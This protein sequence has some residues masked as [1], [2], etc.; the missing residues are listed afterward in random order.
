MKSLDDLEPVFS[1]QVHI[2]ED[3]VG[4]QLGVTPKS[5]IAI[6]GGTDNA[7]TRALEHGARGVAKIGAVVN[8]YA[9]QGEIHRYT[10]P[11]LRRT[12]SSWHSR[13]PELLN[14]FSPW[15]VA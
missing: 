9:A 4:T 3:D 13:Y 15:I 8:D 14:V 12:P 2:D 1:A 11:Q 6:G 10:F 7:E 5:L